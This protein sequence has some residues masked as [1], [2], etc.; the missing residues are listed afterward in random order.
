M[1]IL[2]PS[3]TQLNITLS[4]S[5]F[6]PPHFFPFYLLSFLRSILSLIPSCC[7][8]LH[9]YFHS[10]PFTRTTFSL[11]SII[12]IPSLFLSLSS[13]YALFCLQVHLPDSSSSI[14]SFFFNSFSPIIIIFT[15]LPPSRSFLSSCKKKSGSSFFL[16]TSF[17][18]PSPFLPTHS[19]FLISLSLSTSSIPSFL[20]LGRF[21]C[22]RFRRQVFDQKCTS[23]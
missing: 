8:F 5:F 14:S 9:P 15:P 16:P 3:S 12:A 19:N 22:L 4:C 18:S 13:F 1:N 10:F 2:C 20:S 21:S 7:K 17:R 6:F 23:T 11:H